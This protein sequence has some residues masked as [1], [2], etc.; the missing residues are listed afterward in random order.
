[1]LEVEII[2]IRKFKSNAAHDISEMY[3]FADYQGCEE[4]L[5]GNEIERE[6]ERVYVCNLVV[7]VVSMQS[8]SLSSGARYRQY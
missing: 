6:R 8:V 1:M 3:S 2:K 7:I 5:L 4:R